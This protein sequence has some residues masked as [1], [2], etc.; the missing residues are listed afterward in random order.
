LCAPGLEVDVEGQSVCALHA[1]MYESTYTKDASFG[2]LLYTK[3][4]SFGRL[5]VYWYK[6]RLL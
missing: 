6:K 1:Y 3:D 5:F 4:A 2:R